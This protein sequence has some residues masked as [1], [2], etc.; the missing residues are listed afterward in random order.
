MSIHGTLKTMTVADLLQFLA[1]GQKTGTLKIGHSGIIKQIYLE[2]GLIVGSTSNDPREFLGQVLLHY[3]KITEDQ[4]QKAMDIQRQS[5]GRLGVILSSR[6]FVSQADVMEVLRT[7][8][9]EIIYDLFIWEEADFAF[10][11]MRPMS[12]WTASIA[13]MN[14]H[15]IAG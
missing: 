11:S 5:G 15:A 3:G 6:G 2:N 10:R 7:R 12:S 8:T 9:L 13:S 4:L 14:G 1:A